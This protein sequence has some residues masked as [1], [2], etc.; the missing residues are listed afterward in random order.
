MSLG[1]GKAAA[2]GRQRAEA[3]ADDASENDP[4]LNLIR[5]LVEMLT[6]YPDQVFD[7]SEM[8]PTPKPR[9]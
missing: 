1:A 8:Q 2:V 5:S 7:A 6:G 4:R 9:P 3:S